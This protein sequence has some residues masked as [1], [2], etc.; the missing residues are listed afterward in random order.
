ME[1]TI[2]A[3]VLKVDESVPE[4]EQEG[5]K[6]GDEKA[7]AHFK[8]QVEKVEE[9]RTKVEEVVDKVKTAVKDEL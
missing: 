2:K 4:D 7:G 3:Q 5:S 8:T 9:L 1:F 6:E